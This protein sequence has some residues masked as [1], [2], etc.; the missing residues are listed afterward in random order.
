MADTDD[1]Q[2]AKLY[3]A[4]VNEKETVV[5]ER[6]QQ[7]P[8][9][10]LHV[11]TIHKDTVLHLALYYSGP[12]LVLKLLNSLTAEQ[13]AKIAHK[14]EVGSTILHEV[15]PNDEFVPAAE[16]MVRLNPELL[17]I[18]NDYGETPLFRSARYGQIKMFKCLACEMRKIKSEAECRT[19]HRRRSTTA[20][21]LHTSIVSEHFG[22]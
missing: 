15:A 13:R 1:F 5:L 19:Y 14:N 20:T 11:L 7:F 12:S 9:G 10:P 21:I 22:E 4:I 8:D 16:E 2:N 17:F 6:C 18:L 3:D